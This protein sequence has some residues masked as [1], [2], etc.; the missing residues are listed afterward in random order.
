MKAIRRRLLELAISLMAFTGTAAA[1][2]PPDLSPLRVGESVEIK[3]F[4]K[5]PDTVQS[6]PAL[7]FCKAKPYPQNCDNLLFRF[8]RFTDQSYF[9]LVS[10]SSFTTSTRLYVSTDGG[11][12]PV[13]L[14]TGTP[15]SGFQA[16][17]I[18]GGVSFDVDQQTLEISWFLDHCGAD[19]PWQPVY[20]YALEGTKFNL[21]RIDE[22]QC[23][24]HE[25]RPLW[26]AGASAKPASDWPQPRRGQ[27]LEF[28]GSKNI[29]ASIR[30]VPGTLAGNCADEKDSDNKIYN[31][32]LAYFETSGGRTFALLECEGMHGGFTNV[33]ERTDEGVI[34][35][36]FA[37]SFDDGFFA[38]DY[39][40]E[41]GIVDPASGEISSFQLE[42]ACGE[43]GQDFLK[44][45]RLSPDGF[46]LVK[47]EGRRCL[48]GPWHVIWELQKR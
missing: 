26:R 46:A 17:D 6:L 24:S 11:L 2:A 23:L 3:G 18:L 36:S 5:T 41:T 40:G 1:A 13:F 27:V 19:T 22:S 35:H 37:D 8:V 28:T 47:F 33:F 48:G 30:S 38:S 7:Q 14:T 43:T 12:Q 45:Y 31:P 9:L 32:A 29:P 25:T 21:V 20:H 39:L 34:R 4:H 16:D 42:G 44:T 15:G 10:E